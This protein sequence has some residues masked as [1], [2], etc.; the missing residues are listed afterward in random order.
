MRIIISIDYIVLCSIIVSLT[1][2]FTVVDMP[3]LT[4]LLHKLLCNCWTDIPHSCLVLTWSNLEQ[5]IF[6]L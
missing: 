2:F 1:D 3:L 4:C 5:Q 6:S